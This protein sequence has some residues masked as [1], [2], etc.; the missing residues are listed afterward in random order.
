MKFVQQHISESRLPKVVCAVENNKE[1]ALK[2]DLE[3]H[4]D[5]K[6]YLI[7]VNWTKHEDLL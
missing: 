4:I 3:V 6:R 2:P 1:N 7:D 5:E